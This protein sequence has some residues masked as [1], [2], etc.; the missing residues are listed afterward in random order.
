MTVS[1]LVHRRKLTIA[2]QA[3]WLTRS[4]LAGVFGIDAP[5]AR[6]AKGQL[7]LPGTLVI[8]RIAEAFRHFAT[9]GA[10]DFGADLRAVFG[11][12]ETDEFSTALGGRRRLFLGD[13][14]LG[15]S[16][17]ANHQTRTRIAIDPLDSNVQQGALQ[18]IEQAAAPGAEISFCGEFRLIGDHDAAEG[19]F[20]RA[21]LA[22]EWI[23]Q[24]G[25]DRTTGFGVVSAAKLTEA[26]PIK[27][28]VGIES[29]GDKPARLRLRLRCCDPLCVGD[30][31]TSANTYL[32]SAVIPGAAIKGA[33][34]Q[35]ILASIGKTGALSSLRPAEL[36]ALS[37]NFS[38]LRVSHGFPIEQPKAEFGGPLPVR[39]RRIPFSWAMCESTL[40]DHAL[41]DHPEQPHLI[42]EQAAYFS[43][44]WKTPTWT[45]ANS[46]AG[47]SEPDTELRIRTQIDPQ[48]RA[49]Q[50][51][52][53]FA[54]GY[55]RPDTHDWLFDVDFVGDDP[56]RKLVFAQLLK[57][58][59]EGLAALGRGGAFATLEAVEALPEPDR[60]EPGRVVMVLQTPALLRHPETVVGRDLITGYAA[61]FKTLGI[62]ATLSAVFVR[63]QM[64]GAQ[65]MAKRLPDASAYR[66]WLLAEPGSTFV[67][68][69]ASAQDCAQFA[70]WQISGLGIPAETLA[71]YGLGDSGSELWKHCPWLPENG[72]GEVAFGSTGAVV[73]PDN[74]TVVEGI[75]A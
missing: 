19:I 28:A 51:N 38:A 70:A 43:P 20:R 67:F 53:L 4:T 62:Q 8:G 54:V 72:Y 1:R 12:T 36:E 29:L 39:P 49:A 58:L 14:V 24:L 31:R 44:D 65:F 25:G 2:L 69:G 57:A 50:E 59:S 75:V 47:W 34:A 13:L 9:A 26:A 74:A 40:A 23:T 22:L 11:H 16:H 64:R 63:E 35:Q 73:A 52:R 55:R 66:P 48:S 68:D 21:L 61:A 32:S 5:L 41:L 37:E 7:Y 45:S 71:F 15:E 60:P 18:V 46:M 56:T 6:N 27:S 30:R 10:P 33:L 3:P 17:S 42:N